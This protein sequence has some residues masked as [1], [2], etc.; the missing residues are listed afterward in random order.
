M[1]AN[2]QKVTDPLQQQIPG[3]DAEI[4]LRIG[5]N[6]ERLAHKGRSVHHG[7]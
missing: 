2:A 3:A 5:R 7:S 1:Q 6:I 4:S